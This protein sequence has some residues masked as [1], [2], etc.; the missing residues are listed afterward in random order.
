M[1]LEPISLFTYRPACSLVPPSG[2]RAPVSRNPRRL[3]RT[4]MRTG[5]GRST[6]GAGRLAAAAMALV[7]AGAARA[8]D[9]RPAMEAANARWLAAFNAPARAAFASQYTADA[10]VYFQGS[11]P[12]AGPEA[13]A[14]FWRAR[15]AARHPRAHLRD[16]RDRVGRPRGVAGRAH[17]RA[18]REG[19]RQH[20]HHRPYRADF[21]EAGRRPLENQNP[22]VD[23][24]AV[25]APAAI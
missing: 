19:R 17:H 25:A 10:V 1:G 14:R 5:S 21:R 2:V 15:I 4:D 18:A 11:P 3:R 24:A 12:V 7:V 8:E 23:P 16:R 9:V 13:I 22:H 20:P 6:R